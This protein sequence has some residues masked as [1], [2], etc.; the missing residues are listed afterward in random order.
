MTIIDLSFGRTSPFALVEIKFPSSEETTVRFLFLPL[1]LACAS[2]HVSA[3][4]PVCPSVEKVVE[5]PVLKVNWKALEHHNQRAFFHDVLFTGTAV[6]L[7]Q[8]G[9]IATESNYVDGRQE[10]VQRSYHYDGSLWIE[11]EQKNGR[12]TGFYREWYEN[13]QLASQVEYANGREH[14]KYIGWFSNGQKS[15]EW[16]YEHGVLVHDKQWNKDGE[17]VVD[18]TCP[19][20]QSLSGLPEQPSR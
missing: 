18:Q 20:T 9:E 1:L 4:T 16:T 14:G 7:Y 17:V 3:P 11:E 8:N 15:T 2:K 10:G 5:A 12:P 13:G 6:M 19:C